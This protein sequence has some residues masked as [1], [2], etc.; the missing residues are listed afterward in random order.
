VALS[1]NPSTTNKKENLINCQ[2]HSKLQI[3]NFIS[4]PY[5]HIYV[6]EDLLHLEKGL[7]MSQ[8]KELWFGVNR[9]GGDAGWDNYV[10]GLVQSGENSC[11]LV[12][13][14]VSL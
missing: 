11:C 3:P 6:S 2:L 14:L 1:S 12:A 4:K 10:A 5:K 8:N 9:N 13:Q 7:Y